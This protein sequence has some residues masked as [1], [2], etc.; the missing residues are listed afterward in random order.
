MR[1]PKNICL[2]ICSL[3]CILGS[4][5]SFGALQVT[6]IDA[7]QETQA[8]TQKQLDSIKLRQA[9]ILSMQNLE[10]KIPSLDIDTYD[11]SA[12]Q[13]SVKLRE[14][15]MRGVQATETTTTTVSAYSQIKET[16]SMYFS[17][18][19]NFSREQLKAL[20]L[21]VNKEHTAVLGYKDLEY[22][23]KGEII[24]IDLQLIDSRLRE[25]RYKVVPGSLMMPLQIYEYPDGRSGIKPFSIDSS[26]EPIPEEILKRIA[27][28]EA[29]EKEREVLRE[30][31]AAQNNAAVKT[32]ASKTKV[33]V[34]SSHTVPENLLPK[35][36]QD[37][38][39]KKK[40]N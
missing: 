3:Y 33:I 25:S 34:R 9:N 24:G 21:K 38:R 36:Q 22:D 5:H 4:A 23:N 19:R 10:P 39:T 20:V 18:D 17:I 14:A 16:D 15:N 35:A 32:T 11:T 6:Q 26:Q 8:Q 29:A 13:D 40:N 31:R 37:L 27:A 12:M 1:N 28:Q 2:I 7:I 30:Q